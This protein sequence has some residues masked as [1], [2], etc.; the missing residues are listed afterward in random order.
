MF[1]SLR[2]MLSCVEKDFVSVECAG[3]GYKV[4]V[5]SMTKR[6]LPSQNNQVF[7]YTYTNMRENSIEIFGFKTKEEE[8]CFKMLSSVSGVGPKICLS[9][10]SEFLPEEI[11]LSI[12]SNSPKVLTRVNGVGLK[13]ASR[14]ILELKDKVKTV[15][16][17][18]FSNKD[19]LKEKL[20]I[21]SSCSSNKAIEALVSLG[22]S[23]EQAVLLVS[24]FDSSL[25][26]EELIR[27][28]LKSTLRK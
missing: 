15:D 19:S 9:I 8:F 22:Y 20:R 24:S 1:Y 10:L 6:K 18:I 3:I 28:S 25:S 7:L 27:L 13:L 5:S 17:N 23:K 2:G 21:S 4:F 11:F 16:F 26:A 12:K 14:I